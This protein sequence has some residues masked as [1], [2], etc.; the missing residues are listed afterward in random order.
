[1]ALFEFDQGRLIPAQFGR[2][3]DRGLDP[4]VINAIRSQVLEII[5]RPLFP[6]TWHSDD[7]GSAE[8][9]GA[10]RLTALD[11]SGQVVSVELMVRLE[12]VSLIAAL[13]RLGDIATLGWMDLAQRFPGGAEAFR[14]GWTEFREQMPPSVAPGPRLIIVTG[15]I[16]PSIRPAFGILYQSALEIH[17][18]RLRQMTNGRR[19]LEVMP[20]RPESDM[21]LNALPMGDFA[22]AVPRIAGQV[23]EPEEETIVAPPAQEQPGDMQVEAPVEAPAAAPAAAPAP[24]DV[25][26]PAPAEPVA[27]A[28]QMPVDQPAAEPAAAPGN[29]MF[30]PVTPEADPSRY[31]RPESTVPV[32]PPP[33]PAPEPQAAPVVGS[34]DR[35]EVYDD[36]VVVAPQVHESREEDGQHVGGIAPVPGILGH[37]AEGLQ[38]IAAVIGQDAVL[39]AREG[40]GRIVEALLRS[41]GTIDCGNGFVTNDVEQSYLSVSGR[42]DVVAWQTWRIGHEAG[43]TLA[44]AIDEINAEIYRENQE[45]YQR[46]R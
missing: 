7:D 19:F 18:I 17:E 42:G 26:A 31:A 6:V 13:A 21:P 20:V 25:P 43:P 14:A 29:P 1:M 11:A 36:T 24:Q 2:P 40:D 15:E 27:P 4:E 39:V 44:E 30:Y 23:Q 32:A 28:A 22:N 9:A 41:D 3:V 34:G 8:A 37:N 45:A 38:A 5:A 16:D 35:G 46:Q 10:H 33:A 12:P